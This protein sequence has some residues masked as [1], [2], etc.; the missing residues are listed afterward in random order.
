[1]ACMRRH[2]W[3]PNVTWPATIKGS[4]SRKRASFFPISSQ[5]F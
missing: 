4:L 1:M 3:P 2:V 5:D